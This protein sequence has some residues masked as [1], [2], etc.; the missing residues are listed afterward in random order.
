MPSADPRPL[1]GEPLSLDL[2]NTRW[3]EGAA[4]RDLLTGTGGL[5]VWLESAGLA[6]RCTADEE[7]LAAVRQAREALAAAVTD[8]AEPSGEARAALNDVLA[9]GRVRRVLSPGGPR[10]EVETDRPARLAAWLA[11]DDYLRLLRTDPTRIRACAHPDC[12]L[13]FFDT[14]QNR[15]RRWCSMAACGNRAKATRHYARTRK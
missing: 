12:V 10:D 14:S 3:R 8:P 2:L 15:R 6:A 11:A 4:E 9:H 7:T 1:I 13:H 5:A